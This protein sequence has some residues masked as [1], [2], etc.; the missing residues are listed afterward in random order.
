MIKW[1]GIGVSMYHQRDPRN[2]NECNKLEKAMQENKYA[3]MD[4]K[5]IAHLENQNI[6]TENKKNWKK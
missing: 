3:Y 2:N 5:E 4:T 1:E 6:W